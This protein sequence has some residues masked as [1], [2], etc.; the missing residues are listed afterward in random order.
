M[1]KQE[2]SEVPLAGAMVKLHAGAMVEQES[3]KKT[4][5]KRG[6]PDTVAETLAKWKEVNRQLERASE[7][8]KAT[9]KAPA[10]GSRKGCMR[11]KGGPEN[12][13]CHYRGVR[14]R[15]WGKWVAEIREPNR[16]KRLWL[17][18]LTNA[19]EAARSYDEAAKV[20]YGSCARLNIPSGGQICE[21]DS[22][23]GTTSGAYEST[24]TSYSGGPGAKVMKL[25][26]RDGIS[27]SPDA[28]FNLDTNA[29]VGKSE[30]SFGLEDYVEDFP[31]DMFSVEDMLKVLET[32]Q[33]NGAMDISADMYQHGVH[34]SMN[35][36]FQKQN[37]DA[38]MLGTLGNMEQAPADLDCKYE[39]LDPTTR[40]E[41]NNYDLADD[42]WIFEMALQ[43]GSLF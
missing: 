24:T 15:T 4:R 28:P 36:S 6:G 1:V 5:K 11:G 22:T 38:K 16:G 2:D 30:N 26:D 35:V 29:D 37:L 12:V 20:M 42:S 41:D 17:G 21:K 14:Q 7:S 19:L 40:K 10:I 32:D 23:G 39:F 34:D 3:K 31:I 13:H 27:S 25:E 43:G 9:R 18:T 33:E 8:E